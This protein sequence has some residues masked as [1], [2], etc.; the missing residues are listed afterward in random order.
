[1]KISK[2]RWRH[3]NKTKQNMFF[4]HGYVHRSIECVGVRMEQGTALHGRCCCRWCESVFCEWCW[5]TEEEF[6]YL[7]SNIAF[8]YWLQSWACSPLSFPFFV[9]FSRSFLPLSLF[10]LV[11]FYC[12]K[13]VDKNWWS[14]VNRTFS[15]SLFPSIDNLFFFFHMRARERERDRSDLWSNLRLKISFVCEDESKFCRVSECVS[16]LIS[17]D[18]YRMISENEAKNVR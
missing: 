1:M 17:I 11:G 7:Q 18:C 15:L 10:T 4:E 12:E 13:I 3:P 9:V 16:E 2:Y 5:K 14:F 6:F 8:S